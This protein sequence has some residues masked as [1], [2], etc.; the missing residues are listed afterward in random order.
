MFFSKYKICSLI[1]TK[2]LCAN[3]HILLFFFCFFIC[4]VKA[5]DLVVD[6]GDSSLSFISSNYNSVK[7]YGTTNNMYVNSSSPIV[8]SGGIANRSTIN[9]GKLT[10]DAKGL[11]ND[12]TQD[13]GEFSIGGEAFN[14]T[15]NSGTV[16]V[17]KDGHFNKA[18]VYGGSVF[19][20]E[21]GKINDIILADGAMTIDGIGSNITM[22]KGSII[23]NS[24]ADINTL[25]ATGGDIYVNGQ[26]KKVSLDNNASLYINPNGKASDINIYKNSTLEIRGGGDVSDVNIHESGRLLLKANSLAQN[27]FIDG[28]GKID[29][30]TYA[31]NINGLTF[32]E[33]ASY[34]LSTN[35]SISDVKFLNNNVSSSL[36]D[37][38]ANYWIVNN[39]STFTTDANGVANNTVIENGGLIR[40]YSGGKVYDTTV[41]KGGELYTRDGNTVVHNLTAEEGAVLR[42]HANTILSGDVSIDKNMVSHTLSN[43]NYSNLM[44]NTSLVDKLIISN[45]VNQGFGNNLTTTAPNKHLVLTGNNFNISNDGNNG[46]TTVSGWNILEI[47]NKNNASDTVVKLEGDIALSGSDKNLIIGKDTSLDVSGHSPLSVTID[48]NVINDGIMN[49]SFDDEN[50]EADDITTITGNYTAS[51]NALIVLNVEPENNKADTLVVEG[52]VQGD[53]KV[54]LKSSS[55]TP[56]TEKILFADVANDDETTKSSFNIWRVEGSPYVWNAIYENKKWYTLSGALANN[57]PIIL[58]EVVAYAGLNDAAFYQTNSFASSLRKNILSNNVGRRICYKTNSKYSE[59]YC[60]KGTFNLGTWINPV[61]E[62]AKIDAPIAYDAEVTGIDAGIDLISNGKSKLGIMTSARNGEYSFDDDGDKYVISGSADINIDSYLVGIYYRHDNKNISTIASIYSGLLKADISS[63]DGVSDKVDGVQV[64]ASVDIAT[65]FQVSKSISIEP[66]IRL[67]YATTNFDDIND[68]ANKRVDYTNVHRLETALGVKVVKD[69]ILK[70]DKSIARIFIKPSL[71]H[72]FNFEEDVN[73]G[74]N[75]TLAGSKD[76]TLAEFEIGGEYEFG[77]NL[78]AMASAS[79]MFSSNYENIATDL[80]LKYKF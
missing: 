11:A 20:N 2:S 76:E 18:Y 6:S 12:T 35:A 14:S 25:T 79:Y 43:F 32:S 19:V 73:V 59:Y 54:F 63:D 10:I 41:Q 7:I 22:Q 46:S 13:G 24:H 53:T 27:V 77:N 52:D 80:L 33:N 51:S 40:V 16:R 39:G 56:S 70:N 58:S 50:N 55:S 61:Y 68:N 75:L 8:Y 9:S 64:G 29:A 48:G 4:D 1:K 37:K 34:N 47:A 69:L 21:G 17:L 72:R 3:K 45:G 60:K 57:N 65:K 42:F 66:N 78:S 23:F 30:G 36:A 49:F 44:S 67:G 74:D 5:A 15:I 28:S 62:K 71:I 26:L 38:V 31:V